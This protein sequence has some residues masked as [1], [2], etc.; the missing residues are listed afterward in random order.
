MNLNVIRPKNDK[1]DLLLSSTK[2][3]ETLDEQTHRKA[4]GTLEIKLT[5][6]RETFHFTS[7]ISIQRSWMLGLTSLEVYNSILN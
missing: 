7:L 4:E 3:C 1:E 5:Q 2:N 6:S